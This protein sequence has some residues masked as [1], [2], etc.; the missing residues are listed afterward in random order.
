MNTAAAHPAPAFQLSR[1]FAFGSFAIMAVGWSAFAVALI[2]SQQTLDDVWTAI[3]GLPLV[4]EGLVWL[5]GFPFLLGLLIW[6]ASWDEGIRLTAI[7]ILA[8]AYTYMF[9]PRQR[10]E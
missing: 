8:I 7:A 9:I 6:Q 2:A 10:N 5:L 3:R 4:V 1:L